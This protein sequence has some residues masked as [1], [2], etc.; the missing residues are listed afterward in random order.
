M[1]TFQNTVQAAASSPLRLPFLMRVPDVFLAQAV[2]V[3]FVTT[4]KIMNYM[5]MKTTQSHPPKHIPSD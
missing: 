4:N 5:V 1:S 2:H 3:A